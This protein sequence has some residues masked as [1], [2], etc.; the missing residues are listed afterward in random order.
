MEKLILLILRGDWLSVLKWVNF[1][2]EFSLSCCLI[3]MCVLRKFEFEI[4]RL[5]R[6]IILLILCLK[7]NLSDMVLSEILDLVCLWIWIFLFFM[8]VSVVFV[9]KK[10]V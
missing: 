2:W 7:L 3:G 1:K 8:V 5:F 10:I 4:R 9:L 6:L